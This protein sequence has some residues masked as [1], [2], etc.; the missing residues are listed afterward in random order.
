MSTKH[1]KISFKRNAQQFISQY[2]DAKSQ[3]KTKQL[4]TVS[5][6]EIIYFFT[7]IDIK[8]KISFISIYH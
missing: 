6:R 7:L 1:T 4:K 8:K 3:E 2:L 5:Q